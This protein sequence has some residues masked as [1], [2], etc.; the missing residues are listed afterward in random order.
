LS[1]LTDVQMVRAFQ[2]L[3]ICRD[4]FRAVEGGA[5]FEESRERLVVLKE[6][7]KRHFRQLALTL[8]PDKTNNDPAKTEDFKLVSA[9]VDEISA[10]ELSPRLPSPQRVVLR[11]QFV[12]YG[13]TSTSATTTGFG[14]FGGFGF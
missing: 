13:T 1:R 14:T 3:G 7:V 10:M 12:R 6:R 5:S 4:D 2:L 9:A 11:V 8:H